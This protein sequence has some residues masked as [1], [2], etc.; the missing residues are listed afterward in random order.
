MRATIDLDQPTETRLTIMWYRLSHHGQPEG[1]V[2]KSGMGIHLKVHGQE[3]DEVEMIRRL[4]G[5]DRRRIAIDNRAR[6]KPKQILFS[7][8]GGDYA[9]EWTKSLDRL[10]GQYRKRAPARVRLGYCHSN[11]RRARQ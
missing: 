5:D 3:P 4:C 6:L 7:R 1:R 9:G 8:R 10:I 2:S 11:I